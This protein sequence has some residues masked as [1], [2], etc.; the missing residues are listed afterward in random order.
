MSLA[1]KS[2]M[3]ARGLRRLRISATSIYHVCR[4]RKLLGHLGIIHSRI[5]CRNNNAICPIDSNIIM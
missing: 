2:P 1:L 4:Y 3:T 5:F